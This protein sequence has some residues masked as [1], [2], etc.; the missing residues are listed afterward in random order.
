MMKV[1]L[2]LLA[3]V[4]CS[5]AVPVRPPGTPIKGAGSC[6]ACIQLMDQGIN[7]LLQV[8]LNGG[9]IGGCDELCAHVPGSVLEVACNLLCDFVGIK[10]F[11]K[12][13]NHTDPDPIWYCQ[14]LH[15]CDKVNGGAINITSFTITPESGPVGTNFTVSVMYTVLNATG[16]GIQGIDV[17]GAD[18][19]E[20]GEE[21]NYGDAPGS[22][23]LEFDVPT[24]TN[25]TGTS[26]AV[27]V[28]LCE[29]DCLHK[30]PYSGVYAAATANFTITQ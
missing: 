10:E 28:A 14:E 13:I 26:Y 16:P 12:V 6:D 20:G 24:N 3:L 9:V 2:V 5:L 25:F 7:E 21:F 29:G 30:H 18:I 23:E 27:S 11:I 22:Y 8:I 15:A 4:A 19:D 1:C 17:S